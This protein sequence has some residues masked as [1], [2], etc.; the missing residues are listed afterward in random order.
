[1]NRLTSTYCILQNDYNFTDKWFNKLVIFYVF[2]PRQLRQRRLV[3]RIPVQALLARSGVAVM[4]MSMI[5]RPGPRHRRQQASL[6]LPTRLLLLTAPAAHCRV[7]M[8]PGA[9]HLTVSQG[10]FTVLYSSVILLNIKDGLCDVR[11]HYLCILTNH[12]GTYVRCKVD[13]T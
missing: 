1:M 9:S 8:K 13:H 2:Y 5:S 6:L 7:I 4:R 11:L 12:C 3:Q 10:I